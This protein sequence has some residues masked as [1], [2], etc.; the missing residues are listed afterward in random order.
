VFLLCRRRRRRSTADDEKA[1]TFTVPLVPSTH[2]P[3]TAMNEKI[4]ASPRIDFNQPVAALPL[5]QRGN[6]SAAPSLRPTKVEP[7]Q[8]SSANILS[9]TTPK[10]SGNGE[11][12]NEDTDCKPGMQSGRTTPDRSFRTHTSEYWTPDGRYAHVASPNLTDVQYYLV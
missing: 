1:G 12:S 6:E 3:A 8:T 9:G 10:T 4:R 7:D 5:P 2:Y 11:P